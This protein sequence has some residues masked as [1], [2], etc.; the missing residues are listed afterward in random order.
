MAGDDA[1]RI[2]IRISVMRTAL[3]I[4]L[5]VATAACGRRAKDDLVAPLQKPTPRPKIV[6]SM[7]PVL[8]VQPE[9][10]REAL[11]AS[12]RLR[13]DARFLT[14]VAE[15]PRLLGSPEKGVVDATFE[16]GR[17]TVR[18]GERVVG[19]LP[20][21]PGFGDYLRIL[22]GWVRD[23]E[24]AAKR[25]RKGP[26]NP[27]APDDRG[28]GFLWPRAV[29]AL[30]DVD[31]RWRT[32]GGAVAL[33]A[34][35]ARCLA[36]LSFQMSDDLEI[37]DLLP[38]RG[39]A[40]L[41]IARAAD[42]RSLRREE[43][44][45][46]HAMGYTRHAADVG[47]SLAP[48]DPLRLFTEMA[49]AALA[50]RAA[51]TGSSA[52]TRYLALE[53]VASRDE[54]SEWVTARE[55]L[56]GADDE[57]GLAPAVLHVRLQGQVEDNERREP[58][59]AGVIRSLL[60]ELLRSAPAEADALE[61]PDA[62]GLEQE[63]EPQLAAARSRETGPFWDG[64]ALDA[65]YRSAAYG[66]LDAAGIRPASGTPVGAA[67]QTAASLTGDDLR[68][69]VD[70][71][72]NATEVGEPVLNRI[73]ADVKARCNGDTPEL[74]EVVR[75]VVRRADTRISHRDHLVYLLAAHVL[76][77]R[78]AEVLGRSVVSELSDMTRSRKAWTALYVGDVGTAKRLV[79][80]PECS[81][82]DAMR[83]LWN[84]HQYKTDPEGLE[85]AFEAVVRRY[86]QSWEL[87]YEFIRLLR[88]RKQL[89]RAYDTGAAWIARYARPGVTGYYHSGVV[90]CSSAIRLGK[91]DEAL[92]LYGARVAPNNGRI[93]ALALNG[94][95]RRKEAESRIRECATGSAFGEDLQAWVEILW[96]NGR[97]GDVVEA[98]RS[99]KVPVTLGTWWYQIAP[100]FGEVFLDAPVERP[101]AAIRVL[102]EQHVSPV[103]LGGFAEPFADA[104]K[105]ETALKVQAAIEP[106]S[107]A[108]E[109]RL[110]S[111]YSYMKAWKGSESATQWLK[112]VVPPSERNPICAKAFVAGEFHLLW[113]FIET[114]DPKKHPD[115]VWLF[116]AAAS[117]RLAGNDPHRPDLVAY[118]STPSKDPYHVMGRYLLGL[119]T[120]KELF[121]VAVDPAKRAEVAFYLATKAHGEGRYEEASDWYRVCVDVD[122]LHGPRSVVIRILQR[123][124]EGGQGF[125]RVRADRL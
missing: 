68:A 103:D 69:A 25:W 73:A 54:Y 51:Q 119:A 122:F 77:L 28:E 74:S 3:A 56:F 53:R 49:D 86:P 92:E 72:R 120:E 116:R 20:E 82:Q 50:A 38:A 8:D 88:D 90:Q 62:L 36:R 93:E 11:H 100:K 1:S 64:A 84:W 99:S 117:A 70:F 6:R 57:V 101:L 106:P 12:Y 83:I 46:S 21:L 71:V 29:E 26:G 19:A 32:S 98:I 13:P 52:E 75:L 124:A 61:T 43:L 10:M 81:A 94:L 60:K 121:A 111:S 78:A 112:Q 55:R 80:A 27:A 125:S 14:A 18:Y 15:V 45:L 59:A 67:L 30:R 110:M 97:D 114:P 102:R 34:E 48:G 105:F 87:N 23:R 79:L 37:G 35:A 107:A 31:R 76:D 118:Y 41:A 5:A 42:A 123:W 108:G 17:W 96:R 113:D 7:S 16:S 85:T 47:S 91:Y 44:L 95:G 22:T 104:G 58:V 2:G 89:Q 63:L 9:R 66:G 40:A 4:L 24:S 39:L 115:W 33:S 109:E 65:W